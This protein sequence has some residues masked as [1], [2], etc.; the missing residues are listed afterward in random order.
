MLAFFPRKYT[1][2]IDSSYLELNFEKTY[3]SIVDLTYKPRLKDK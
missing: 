1:E 2:L 3:E